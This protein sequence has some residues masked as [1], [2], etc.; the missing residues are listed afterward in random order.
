MK[1]IA[2]AETQINNIYLYF[3]KFHISIMKL[4]MLDIKLLNSVI[5]N[6]FYSALS[7]I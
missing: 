4:K 5:F 7:N 6:I 1:F 2:L 3:K